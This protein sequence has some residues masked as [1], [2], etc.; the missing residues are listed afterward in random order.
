MYVALRPTQNTINIVPR[1]MIAGRLYRSGKAIEAFWFIASPV[2]SLQMC[3]ARL[4]AC[5]RT[6]DQTC[7]HQERILANLAAIPADFGRAVSRLWAHWVPNISLDATFRSTSPT[8]ASILVV[9]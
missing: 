5:L 4:H 7:Q 1:M 2:V 6:P 8:F 3:C 9:R